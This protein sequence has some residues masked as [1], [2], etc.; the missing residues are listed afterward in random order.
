MPAEPDGPLGEIAI[1]VTGA[2]TT[3]G[4][5]AR[6]D[7]T[8]VTMSLPTTVVAVTAGHHDVEVEG[9]QGFTPFGETRLPVEVPPG[10]RA[11]LHYALPRTIWSSGR[12]GTAPQQ[13]SW[14]PH[15]GNIAIGCGGAILVL[16]LLVVARLVWQA[17]G[18]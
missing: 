6:V 7:G 1:H 2:L 3:A 9:L 15:W 12:L 14:G 5:R 18:G 16:T 17:V 8:Q 4:V 10:H 11:D 13:R